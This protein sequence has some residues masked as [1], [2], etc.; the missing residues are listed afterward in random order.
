MRPTLRRA[1]LAAVLAAVVLGLAPALAGAAPQGDLARTRDKIAAAKKQKATLSDQIATLDGRLTAID[2]ELARLGDQ[3]GVVEQK[4]TTTRAK[5][6][7]LQEQLR[8]KRLELQAAEQ[9]LTLEQDNFETRVVI[10]YKTDDLTYVDVVLASTS[11]EDLVSRM[12]VMHDLIG[13]NNELVGGLET[14][15]DKVAH[16]K[17]TIA[18]KETGVHQAVNDLQAQSDQLAALR[19]AQA[20]Q[21]AAS[22]A[23]RRQ[24]NTTLSGV[25][26]DL[27]LLEQ[28]ENQLLAESSALTGVI[29]GSSGS[30]VGTGTMMWPVN[31]P[32][33]SPFGYRIHPILGYRK[34]HTGVDFGVGY[35]TPI[36][37]AD[38]GTVI[39]ATW[40]SGY[41]NVTI[42]DHGRGISTLYG[43]QS[44]L[45]VGSGTPVSRG[46]VIGYVGSTGFS[47]GPHLHFE[48]R[49]NGTPVDPM[50]YLN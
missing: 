47:T 13:G 27:A 44:S 48:V 28:Q 5:L 14:T 50:G 12:N 46:Q 24:K 49:V 22:L 43:H 23:M 20:A 35:G 36:H 39:Y 33:T 19:A 10:A 11:Y 15:R 45:A 41:G 30:G 8:L 6:K 4:L 1:I 17:Q 34:L 40:M 26:N 42:I 18:E 32:I 2:D 37:A 31:G 3:I 7:I 25:E 29:T 21:K 9:E 16:E 38:S